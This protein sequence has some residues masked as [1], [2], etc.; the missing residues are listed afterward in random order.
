MKADK[1]KILEDFFVTHDVKS[2]VVERPEGH[3]FTP[4][5]ATEVSIDRDGWRE[6]KR[7]FTFTS[8]PGDDFLQFI[9]KAYPERESVTKKLLDVGRGDSLL[10]HDVFGT[11]TY[12]G[13]GT[14]IAGGAGITPFIAI[15]RHLSK[16]GTLNGNRLLFGNKTRKDIILEDEL[17]G[18]F[19]SAFHNVLSD[20]NVPGYDHG[21]IDEAYLRKHR[22]GTKEHLYLCGPPPMMESI[23]G[24]LASLGVPEEMIIK[25]GL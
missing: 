7:P 5:Q 2:F 10:L 11:I 4:G 9:I 8:L 14:F 3:T 6:E 16:K 24:N 1:V 25:E 19:G 22:P 18:L 12:H 23:E 13:P 17:R 20:E 21:I 15:F